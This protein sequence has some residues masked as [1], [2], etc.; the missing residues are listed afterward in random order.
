MALLLI[1][2]YIK[3]ATILVPIIYNWGEVELLLENDLLL[4]ESIIL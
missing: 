3:L 4:V 1:K 2:L